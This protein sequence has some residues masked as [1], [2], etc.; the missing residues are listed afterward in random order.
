MKNT[1]N[2]IVKT[3]LKVHLEYDFQKRF[4]KWRRNETVNF[5]MIYFFSSEIVSWMIPIL[6]IPAF[7]TFART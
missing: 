5:V 6:K 7:C 1:R 2:R 4:L 3:A